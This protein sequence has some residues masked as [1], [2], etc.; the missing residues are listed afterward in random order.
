MLEEYP[1][2]RENIVDALAI[3]LRRLHSIPVC[4]CPFTRDRVF[5]L[6]LAQSRMSNGLVDLIMNAM[7]GLLSKFGKRCILFCHYHPIKL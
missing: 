4:N 3:F 6:A 7:A 5:R 2:S 1:D